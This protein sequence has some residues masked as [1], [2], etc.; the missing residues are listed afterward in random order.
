MS[1]ILIERQHA[2][3]LPVVRQHAQ[4]WASKAS[5]KFGV[6]YRYEAGDQQD[7]LHFEGNGI[8]GQLHVTETQLR[9]QAQLGFLA[10]MFQDQIEA[11][12]NAQFDEMLQAARA[13]RFIIKTASSTH[14]AS[15]SSY[16]F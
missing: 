5:D 4:T 2:L 16:I 1:Q 11:K 10:A 6:Q 15:A 14:P 9:L 13:C 3:G 7:V 12:L 8:E